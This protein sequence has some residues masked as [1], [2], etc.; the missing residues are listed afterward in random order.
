MEYDILAN[1]CT[2][3]QWQTSVLV[4]GSFHLRSKEH[5]HQHRR[6]RRRRHHHQSFNKEMTERISIHI[7]LEMIVSSVFTIYLPRRHRTH[8]CNPQCRNPST[9]E[10]LPCQ[11]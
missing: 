3:R 8:E 2:S 7:Y 10:P 11:T 4:L 6:R 1:M 9:I 5:H